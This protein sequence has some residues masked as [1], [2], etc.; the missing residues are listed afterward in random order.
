MWRCRTHDARS[1]CADAT[2]DAS[3]CRVPRALCTWI[4]HHFLSLRLFSHHNCHDSQFAT[5]LSLLNL[6]LCSYHFHKN[7]PFLHCETRRAI[8]THR[9]AANVIFTTCQGQS[10]LQLF[11]RVVSPRKFPPL[12][13]W[14]KQVFQRPQRT[15]IFHSSA[16]N[17]CTVLTQSDEIWSEHFFHCADVYLAVFNFFPLEHSTNAGFFRIWSKSFPLEK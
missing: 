4:I 2:C 5:C 15:N 16:T 17:Y 13:M 1:G 11:T 10:F 7:V 9:A 3:R 14:T 8:S 6:S 12:K